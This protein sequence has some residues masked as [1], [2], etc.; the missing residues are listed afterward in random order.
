LACGS[1]QAWWISVR[2]EVLILQLQ[3]S[4]L[5]KICRCSF[6]RTLFLTLVSRTQINICLRVRS[7]WPCYKKIKNPDP[8]M[9]A[10]LNE[11]ILWH[12]NKQCMFSDLFAVPCRFGFRFEKI[13]SNQNI[14]LIPNLLK[15]LQKNCT[16]K[17]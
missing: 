11:W 3:L 13:K 6:V 16:N 8:V 17:R 5:Q 12:A 10:K 9:D 1:E 7:F 15:Y 2:G 14:V 4:L